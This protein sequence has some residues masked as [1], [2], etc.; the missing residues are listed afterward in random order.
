MMIPNSGRSSTERDGLSKFFRTSTA[1]DEKGSDHREIVASGFFARIASIARWGVP[2]VV[3]IS[4]TGVL[5]LRSDTSKRQMSF[6]VAL[7]L[8]EADFLASTRERQLSQKGIPAWG[9]EDPVNASRADFD[10]F[11]EQTCESSCRCVEVLD[12]PRDI[13]RC[14]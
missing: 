5:E 11:T 13:A 7:F 1:S 10:F 9:S 6:F 14:R 2:P 8:G 12:I 3:V 4:S